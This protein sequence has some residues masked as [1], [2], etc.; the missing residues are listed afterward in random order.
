M[1]IQRPTPHLYSRLLSPVAQRHLPESAARTNIP[2]KK[3]ILFGK[4]LLLLP[5]AIAIRAMAASLMFCRNAL[6]G[7][8]LKIGEEFAIGSQHMLGHHIMSQ[9]LEQFTDGKFSLMK[10]PNQK[11]GI[12]DK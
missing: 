12:S 1:V 11:S 5:I 10:A 4:V 8:S 7:K 2:A 6:G 3:N 9:E